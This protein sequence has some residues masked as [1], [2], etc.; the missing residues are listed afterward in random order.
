MNSFVGY[1]PHPEVEGEHW[2]CVLHC[3]SLPQRVAVENRSSKLLETVLA[4]LPDVSLIHTII[5]LKSHRVW[6]GTFPQTVRLPA[7]ERLPLG[8]PRC[9]FPAQSEGSHIPSCEAHYGV[10][11]VAKNWERS[12]DNKEWEIEAPNSTACEELNPANN[13]MSELGRESS[14]SWAFRWHCSPVRELNCNLM[15]DSEAEALSQIVPRFPT[16]RNWDLKKSLLF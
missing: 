5:A 3:S 13:H 7:Y 16:H 2:C 10:A 14:S 15:R 11:H 6:L 12:L 4:V 9:L 8:A 1:L